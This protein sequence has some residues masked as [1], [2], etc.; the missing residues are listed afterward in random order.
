[1]KS[2]PSTSITQNELRQSVL[3]REYIEGAAATDRFSRDELKPILLGLFGEVGSVMATAKKHRREEE[4]Y[5]G[6]QQAVE[7]EFGDALWYFTALCR[8]LE[9]GVDE[10]LSAAT[11]NGK[12]Q[13]V[14]AA[15][16]LL[17]GPISEV[18][19]VVIVPPLDTTLLS[20]GQA[21]A[22]LLSITAGDQAAKE[23]LIV[24]ADCYLHALQASRV[25]FAEVV[26]MNLAKTCGRF[27][28]PDRSKLPTFDDM[29]AEE[30]RLPADFQITIS[31]RKS[32]PSYLQMNGVFIGDPLTDNISDSD[33]YRFHDV[34]HFAHAAV[35]HW[36]PTFRALIKHKR[37]SDRLLEE[38]QD[39]GR[40]IVVEEG[41][42]AWI[43]SRAKQLNFFEGQKGVSF[44]LLKTVSQ[45]VSG[46]EVEECPLKLWE[47]AILQGYAVFRQVKTNNGGTVIGRRSD[48]R[49][50]YRQ[51]E[52]K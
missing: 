33:G 30:E 1:M 31:Q 16:D 3:L 7:E 22:N 51:L 45:F 20:L 32:G 18:S 13:T 34:F 40:A 38:A 39:S 19:T 8:R 25:S 44:D 23:S 48:R 14:V 11:R 6:Y 24:F 42:S 35:L 47:D 10:V 37:K 41:L 2:I 43:F 26:R 4:A 17:A 36:S 27:L 5:V 52:G 28:I 49:V 15:S 21:A 9:L 46:Y 29:F 50:E 12:Y